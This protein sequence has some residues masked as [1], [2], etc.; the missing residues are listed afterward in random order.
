MVPPGSVPYFAQE[1]I[2]VIV[3]ELYNIDPLR[4]AINEFAM[5][6]RWYLDSRSL[7]ALIYK[8]LFFS[9]TFHTIDRIA[10]PHSQLTVCSF[11][12]LTLQA[13]PSIIRSAH[14]QYRNC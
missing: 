14:N 10:L 12:S 9:I 6:A 5:N 13:M 2:D 11:L 4:R 7:P 1:L 3:D 8:P